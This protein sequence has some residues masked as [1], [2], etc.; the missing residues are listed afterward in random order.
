MIGNAWEWTQDWWE[1][2]HTDSP[3]TNPVRTF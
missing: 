3:K 1:V 2:K